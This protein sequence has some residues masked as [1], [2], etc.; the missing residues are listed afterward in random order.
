MKTR[1]LAALSLLAGSGLLEAG[2]LTAQVTSPPTLAP[3]PGLRMPAVHE[4]RLANGM[5]LVVVPMHEVPLVHV[6]LS[7]S[8]GGREDGATPGLATFTA[9]MLDK[10]A[11]SRDAN[12]IAADV[13]YL[14]ASLFA[15]ADWN[16]TNLSL[17]V[18]KRS[19]SPALDIMAD[20]ALRPAFLAT[21]VKR[22]RDLRLANLLQQRDNPGAVASLNYNALV[23]P[24]GHPYHRP[25][26]GDSSA[27]AGLDSAMVRGFY[28]RSFRPD[29]ATMIITGDITLPEARAEIERRFGAWKSV[30]TGPSAP[31]TA[32]MPPTRPTTIYLVDKPG[33]AQ[34]VVRIGHRGVERSNPDYYA[35]QVM[36]TL[37]GGSFSSRLMSNLR[38]TKGY[39]YGARSAFDFQPVPGAFTASADVRSDVTDSSLVEFFKE[40]RAIREKPVDPAELDRTKQYLALRVP[41]SF[42]TTSQVASQVGN[43]LTFGLPFTWFDDYVR[44]IM[45]VTAEDVQRVARRYIQPDSVSVVIVGDVQKIRPGVEKL[46]LGPVEVRKP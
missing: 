4:A 36:N 21:E 5:R 45:S 29:R 25:L 43:L 10:G 17:R 19:L 46:G 38:E 40:L 34:S 1:T 7:V 12:T 3:P 16:S 37:L 28:A 33:A 39:T 35:V 6:I 9:G 14:G 18:P 44:R 41:G 13:A 26:G 24:A 20:V 22:Q 15:G 23:F 11:G 32:A 8:G 31:S 2:R 27:T 30:A 42:E